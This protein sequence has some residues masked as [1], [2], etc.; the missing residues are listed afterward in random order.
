MPADK[1]ILNALQNA[2]G[3]ENVSTN[4][5]VLASYSATGSFQYG[6]GRSDVPDFV[7]M[8]RT[9]EQVQDVLR[10]ADRYRVP[11]VPV[12][13]SVGSCRPVYGGIV[14]DMS[15]MNHILDINVE[16]GY[17]LIEPGVTFGQL[18]GALRAKGYRIP[19]GSFPPTISVFGP[20][21]RNSNIT[22]RGAYG[23]D[24]TLCFEFVLPDGTVVRS[25]SAAFNRGNWNM[26]YGPYPYIGGL[27]L[28]SEGIY[29][30][31][32]KYSVRIY[33]MHERQEMPV[34]A[35]DDFPSSIA[36]QSRVCRAR[37]VEHVVNFHYNMMGFFNALYGETDDRLSQ[38][39]LNQH[40]VA[41]KA[42]TPSYEK[43]PHMPYNM[44]V[45]VLSGTDAQ[46]END[47][48]VIDR[49]AREL[50]GRTLSEKEARDHAGPTYEGWW[51]HSYRD[52]ILPSR[53]GGI[54]GK[55]LVSIGSIVILLPPSKMKLAERDLMQ[56]YWQ[57]GFPS[58]YYSQPFDQNRT[59][60]LRLRTA[61]P[62]GETPEEEAERDRMLNTTRRLLSYVMQ[63]YGAVP[64]IKN[65]TQ[66]GDQ[67]QQ[68]Y[69]YYTCLRKIKQGLDPNDILNPGF[70]V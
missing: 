18:Q 33:P 47:L 34:V 2:V 23:M 56:R 40:L 44:N 26:P 9:T 37:L 52:H 17:A 39:L 46:V 53:D 3:L 31:V 24:D 12:S 38:Q 35:F 64:H 62:L 49:C 7:V 63:Q 61:V 13:S 10:I 36:W 14:L 15:E 48:E 8:P 16:D 30:V 67:L 50:G 5:A 42:G 51:E 65:R 69:G 45:A 55:F 68:A 58:W 20:E 29:G 43:P 70:L 66:E 57:E 1:M 60:F 6:S 28:Q 25:G 54:R 41:A 21:T 27:M 11:V 19:F 59:A 32:T 4:T 22:M